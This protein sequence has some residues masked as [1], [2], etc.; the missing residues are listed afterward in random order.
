[1]PVCEHRDDYEGW[2]SVITVDLMAVME[3]I[4]IVPDTIVYIVIIVSVCMI[5][6]FSPEI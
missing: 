2:F 3:A 4:V 1:M 6:S 5:S